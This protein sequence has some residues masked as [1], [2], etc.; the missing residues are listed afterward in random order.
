[1][2]SLRVVKILDVVGHCH[3]EFNN[4]GL[5]FTVEKFGLHSSP[6]RFDHRVVIA[7][8]DRA[9]AEFKSVIA[10]VARE[11]PGRKLSGFNRSLQHRLTELTVVVR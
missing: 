3:A 4:G 1:M 6:E 5:G 9:E 11:S 8:T 2:A 10:Y 7:I